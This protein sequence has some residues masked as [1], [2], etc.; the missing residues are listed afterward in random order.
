M[1]KQA[2][3][4]FCSQDS[5]LRTLQQS[6]ACWCLILQD[7]R[8]K[9][10]VHPL[11]ASHF[12]FIAGRFLDALQTSPQTNGSIM[13]DDSNSKASI[14]AW[15]QRNSSASDSSKSD[16]PAPSQ[17]Q[18]SDDSSA[19]TPSQSTLLEQATKFL[20]DESI[21][22]ASKEQKI[23][24][25][26]S[27]G[28]QRNHIESLLEDSQSAGQSGGVSA[29]ETNNTSENKESSETSSNASSR[30]TPS[31]SSS[32]STAPSQPRD[33]PPI[34]TYPEFLTKQTK[35]PP[36]VTLNSILYTIYG[37]M[38]LGAS[39]YG[40]S[41]YLVKPMLANLTS[42][43]HEFAQ[44]TQGNLHKLNEKLEQSV[45]V[46]PP[47]LAA[48]QQP[49]KGADTDEN[50]DDDADSVTSDPTELFH[51]DVATQT[52][53]QDLAKKEEEGGG[54]EDEEQ[55]KQPTPI[56]TV[57][58]H[59]KRMETITSHLRE[60][61]DTETESNTADETVRGTLRDL[62]YYLDGLAYSNPSYGSVSYGTWSSPSID[63][64]SSSLKTGVDKSEEEAMA[65]FRSEIR[66]VKGALLSARNFPAG[67]GAR[68]GSSFAR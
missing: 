68:I 33:M 8:G 42:A 23:A 9:Y 52:T 49:N 15:Q 56:E 46:I 37:A 40:A 27:K 64:S 48:G 17:S 10:H 54:A 21:R 16:T 39:I 3:D 2:L 34:I 11:I 25:L 60:F 41:E 36:L 5:T 66:G 6:D 45:S 63:S 32:S 24:F 14:P 7:S 50:D 61:V 44:T 28:L 55:Q 13:A 47:S 26:E 51:R 67:R 43:R 19:T 12:G 4:L 20:Q 35:P 57:T 18:S 1:A 58:S 62:H 65:S 22:D 30:I 29:T 38:G 31:S 59:V 53:S